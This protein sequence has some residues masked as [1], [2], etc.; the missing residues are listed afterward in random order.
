MLISKKFHKIF[1]ILLA[2]LHIQTIQASSFTDTVKYYALRVADVFG[3]KRDAGTAAM[4][5]DA[6]A[7]P[8]LDAWTKEMTNEILALELEA[9]NKDL[10]PEGY[11]LAKMQRIGKIGAE[12]DS[13]KQQKKAAQ[14]Y[15]AHKKANPLYG[16]SQDLINNVVYAN[17]T[18]GAMRAL[19]DLSVPQAA[20]TNPNNVPYG[21]PQVAAAVRPML[22]RPYAPLTPSQRAPLMP[23]LEKANIAAQET[24]LLSGP[25]SSVRSGHI[26]KNV[27]ILGHR[28]LQNPQHAQFATAHQAA[29]IQQHSVWRS[30]LV[31][32]TC[33][34]VAST[35]LL[36]LSL[37]SRK[38]TIALKKKYDLP[39]DS[40]KLRAL[41]GI[42][43]VFD[44]CAKSWVCNTLANLSLMYAYNRHSEKQADIQAAKLTSN[45]TAGAD[46]YQQQLN[47]TPPSWANDSRGNPFVPEQP[48]LSDRVGYLSAMAQDTAHIKSSN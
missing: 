9:L 37:G 15:A 1:F 39:E 5:I 45:P 4:Q 10:I 32:A 7:R 35:G 23:I 17:I 42:S 47:A 43:K 12:Q 29:K 33:P 24:V 21:L 20:S 25:T 8:T 41:R 34:V 14:E 3:Y 31:A 18:M 30:A 11:N 46:Y 26:N 2:T 27:I 40:Y 22:A 36:A 13:I 6:F 44:Y 28:D 16:T 48:L 38:L 19:A